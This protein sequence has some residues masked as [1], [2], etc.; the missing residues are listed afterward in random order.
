MQAQPTNSATPV[1]GAAVT[2]QP[3]ANQPAAAGGFNF[4]PQPNFN[5]TAG[6]SAPGAA[7]FQFRSDHSCT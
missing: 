1:F 6:A 5:F 7:N 2:S 4:S 3:Q